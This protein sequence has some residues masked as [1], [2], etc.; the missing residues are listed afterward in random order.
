MKPRKII[1]VPIDESLIQTG[2]TFQILRLDGIDP[3]ITWAMGSAV[4]NLNNEN[5]KMKN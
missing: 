2:D 1:N 3:M 5:N 4:G